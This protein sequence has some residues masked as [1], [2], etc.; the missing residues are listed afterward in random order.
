M[1]SPFRPFFG[2]SEKNAVDSA[3]EGRELPPNVVLEEGF[4]TGYHVYG[5]V[6]G[7]SGGKQVLVGAGDPATSRGAVFIGDGQ[8]AWEKIELP[9]ETAL[10]SHFVRLPDGRYVAGGMSA[11]G[12]GAILVSDQAARTW[13]PIDMD[14]H[15]F[16]AIAALLLLKDGTILA[17]A[18]K[19]IT[20]GKTKPVL[21]RSI[22]GAQTWTKEELDLPITSFISFEQDDDGSVF[23][24]TTGD[25]TPTMYRSTDGAKTWQPLPDFPAHKTYKMLTVRLVEVMGEKRL[26]VV[27]WG[28]KIDIADRVV[29]I[30]MSSP[31]FMTWEELP[32][33]ADSHFIFS[34]LVTN[35]KYFYVGSEKG[36]I[37]RSIDFG[38]HWDEVTQFSTNIGAYALHEDETGRVWIGKDFVPPAERSLWRIAK[39]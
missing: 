11:I 38:R 25:H 2:N 33:I 24:G 4:P 39:S 18:G 12:R 28:Y 20:Q 34:F 23:A 37:Y 22:D 13:T 16:S 29:R 31:D 19:M 15:P 36:R 9:E 26:F 7:P 1:L 14:L 32:A 6:A 10:L 5:M 27:L 3:D 35:A 17:S 30:Y 8:G 21:F